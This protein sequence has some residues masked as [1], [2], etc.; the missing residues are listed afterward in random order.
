[1]DIFSLRPAPI[2]IAYL[3]LAITTGGDYYDYVVVDRFVVPPEYEYYYSGEH[4]G[5]C[6]AKAIENSY[7]IFNG[8]GFTTSTETC[9]EKLV[10]M[11]Y[12]YHI[13]DHKQY[14]PYPRLPPAY[15]H[16]F[17]LPEDKFLYCNHANN[18]RIDPYLF[19]HW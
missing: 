17:K 16:Q 10:V 6:E 19:D 11:P 4:C 2:Q 3:G 1:M 5:C 12:Q 18:Y 14:Y 13:L 7:G 15:R 9:V 8:F